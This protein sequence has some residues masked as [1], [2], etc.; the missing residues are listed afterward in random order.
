MISCF[1]VWEF[2]LSFKALQKL[3]RTDCG[4]WKYK[5]CFIESGIT[6]VYLDGQQQKLFVQIPESR[7]S[8]SRS[9]SDLVDAGSDRVNLGIQGISAK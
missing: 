1:T 8:Q 6:T 4:F 3:N 9:I 2:Y 7:F 5:F